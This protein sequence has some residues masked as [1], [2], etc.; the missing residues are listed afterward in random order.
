MTPLRQR[1]IDRMTLEGFSVSTQRAYLYQLTEV[2]RYFRVS[3]DQLNQNDI[4]HYLLY[5]IRE[6][7]WSWSSCRQALHALN[8]LYRKVAN[9]EMPSVSL[10]HPNE[11]QKIPDLLYP[12][13]VQAMI[14][15][16]QHPKVY[17][18][19]VLAYTTGMRISEI[20]ALRVDDL[21]LT[22]HCI[23]V[24]QGKGQQD[25]YV[26]FP[27]S[28]QQVLG[29]YWQRYEPCDVV[30]YGLDKHR[31]LHSKYLRLETKEAAKRAGIH[32][33]IRFHSLRHAFACHQLLAGMPLPRLQALLGHKQIQTTFRYLQWIA[34]MDL[35]R[36]DSEDLLPSDWCPS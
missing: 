10:P 19:M 4:Q 15:C 5:L 32:K 20:N 1:V 17:V 14:R 33:C 34:M 2:A 31:P 3:P 25:R 9:K 22:H 27:Q 8:F 36:R 6:R 30:V 28:L 26:L 18:A 16:C 12:D 21:D 35:K 13:E 23:K 11:S 29:T 24:R 7:G